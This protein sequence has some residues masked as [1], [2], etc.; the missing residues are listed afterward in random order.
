MVRGD[1]NVRGVA[2]HNDALGYVFVLRAGTGGV[3]SPGPRTAKNALE[4]VGCYLHPLGCVPRGNG[5]IREVT[6]I[7]RPHT[8]SSH[9]GPRV[10][11]SEE[12][13]DRDGGVFR[14][15]ALSAV[16]HETTHR[17]PDGGV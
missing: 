11:T 17:S 8:S 13:Y 3:P 6:D 4:D 5:I 16:V 10:K 7:H 15:C 9:A 1:V 2:G 14:M 12:R